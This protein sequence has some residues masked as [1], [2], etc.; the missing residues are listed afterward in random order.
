MF[1]SVLSMYHGALVFGLLVFFVLFIYQG[2]L[3][4]GLDPPPSCLALDNPAFEAGGE[5]RLHVSSTG[6]GPAN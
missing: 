2:T 5:E 3:V 4:F 6:R 1:F